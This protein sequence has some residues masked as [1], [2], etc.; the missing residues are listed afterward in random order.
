MTWALKADMQ[1]H[2]SGQVSR[3]VDIAFHRAYLE[4]GN[5]PLAMLRRV[6]EQQGLVAAR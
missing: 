5:M 3:E 4:A 2:L 1:K 6:F